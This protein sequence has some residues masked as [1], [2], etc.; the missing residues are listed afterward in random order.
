[1]ITPITKTVGKG[2]LLFSLMSMSA[3]VVLAQSQIKISGK[4]S[5]STGEPLVGVTVQIKGV[6]NGTVTDGAGNY[7]ILARDI[8]VLIF[9]LVGKE[10]AEV[11]VNK[12]DHI[13]LVLQES[14]SLIDEVVVVGY[15]TQKK[16]NL[17]GAVAAVD[18]KVLNKRIATNP[19]QLLQ[20][21]MP[22]L[23]VTQGSGEAGNENVN[24]QVRGL[25]SYGASSAPLV[26]V[27]GIPGSLE[28]LNPQA[29]ENI[30]LLKD[31]ASAAIYGAR[32]A[33]GV[34]LV[35]T[36]QGKAG[37]TQLSY[38]YNVGI[39][40]ASALPDLV[41]NSV[42]YMNLYNQANKNSGVTNPNASF[43][44]EMIDAYKNATDKKL[45]PDFNWLD[46]VFGTVPV[47]THNLSLSGGAGG[48]NY[49]VILGYVNQP[50][51]MIGTSFKK[52]NL[53]L[54][55]GSKIN[56]RISF[57]SSITLNYGDR[58]YP[59]NGS[60]DQFLSTISQSPLY[61]PVLPD[62]SGRY[63]SR[64]YP[65]QS[66]NKNPVAVAENAFTR[67]NNYFMQGNIF[68]NVKILDGLDWK[69]S[70]GL[71]YGFTKNYTNKPV[72][73]QYMWFAK[74]DDLPARQLD[75]GGQGLEVTDDNNVYPV[76]YTQLTYDKSFGNHNMKVLAGTQ[77]EYNKTQKLFGSRLQFP[78]NDL[79]E[80]DGGGAGQ[81]SNN[82]VT[83]EW[84][85]RSYYG[86]LNYDY[87]GKY[88]L[89]GNA[90]Y[91][92]SS[93]FPENRKWAFFPS[94]S[95]GWKVSDETFYGP[96]LKTVVN[97]L[98]LRASIG[99]LGNQN[100]GNYPYQIVYNSSFAYPFDETLQQGARQVAMANDRIKWESTKVLDFGV[101]FGLWNNKLTAS[102]DWYNKVTSDILSASTAFPSYIGLTAPTVNYGELRNRGIELGLQYRD[103]IGEVSLTLNGNIQ[104]NRNKVMKYGAEHIS[105]NTIIREGLPYGSFYLLE[106]TGIFRS[107]EEVAA[108]P[109]QQIP[110][111][112]GY[113][114]FADVNGDKVVDNND[115]IVVP[116][117]YPDFDYSFNAT[118]VWKNF[119]FTA[120]FF[121][122][123]GQ[124]IF[125]SEWGIVP[126][127]QGGTFTRD[128]MDAWTPEN[129]NA[130]LPI[131]GAENTPA[132]NN[133]R[134]ASTFFL[135]DGSFLRLKNIQVGYSIPQSTLSKAGIS[136][137]RI[138]FAAD[139]LVTFSKFPGLDPER[140]VSSS[141]GATSGRYVTHPQN[142]VFAF[143]ASITF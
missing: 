138:Y 94:I 87:K 131:V 5:S 115:R 92:A 83:N 141:G 65:F 34:I 78:N 8:D 109:V 125:V 45:Y 104:A 88:L 50:D 16:S 81:Q 95:G 6:K 44:Q 137:L 91:D 139:N 68:L 118:A 61:G 97:E 66:P 113:L 90:R 19:T 33:N 80:L 132:A 41:Y 60:E 23:R 143:G 57:G 18:G 59:R 52:Y 74:P 15:G 36:K 54:N 63:T 21:R 76:G 42:D 126:F 28:N 11:Q 48:T 130:S 102:F 127:R 135:K 69:T 55:L 128:W 124:K 72:I 35:T 140:G 4:V 1:M 32:A 98:K 106:N 13:N 136:G 101:D 64:A 105:G 58:K 7:Q 79:L 99:T 51:I 67:L 53:Q 89:E 93:R 100:I 85:L 14:S 3:P 27:D 116:G 142:K 77:A 47:Q 112:P 26:I 70:G 96:K 31:A 82:G 25:G 119:D 75:V 46:A 110:A 114:K 117:A 108:S 86:R 30:T 56:E 84:S 12:K 40:K 20:G 122:S 10:K 123:Q 39:T 121:G 38:D 133:V 24:L 73:N 43:S 17:T 2:L 71:T 37:K 22:G 9:S 129:P 120:F 103:K 49:N 62:G 111:Q 134:T 107:K 29:I